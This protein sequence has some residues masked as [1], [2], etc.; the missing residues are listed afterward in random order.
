MAVNYPHHRYCE[1][2]YGSKLRFSKVFCCLCRSTNNQRKVYYTT[3][4]YIYYD[5]TR[6]G[7]TPSNVTVYFTPLTP[8]ISTGTGA[9]VHTGMN[10]LETKTDSIAITLN[11][12]L[13]QGELVQYVIGVS[14]GFYYKID[15]SQEFMVNP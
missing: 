15:P 7:Q 11:G 12:G 9:F 6:L 10:L 5:V 8:N 3:N 2:H 13:A 1:N 4:T 14:N